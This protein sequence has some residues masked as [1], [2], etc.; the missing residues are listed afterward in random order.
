MCVCVCVYCAF[1][2]L[3]NKLSP[4]ARCVQQNNSI[5]CFVLSGPYAAVHRLKLTYSL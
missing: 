1:V 5:R 3:D 2:G 4:D